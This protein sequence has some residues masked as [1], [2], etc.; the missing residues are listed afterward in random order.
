MVYVA[1]GR[2]V[3]VSDAEAAQLQT[4]GDD[5]FM[6]GYP[7]GPECWRKHAAAFAKLLKTYDRSELLALCERA[8]VPHEKW[9]NRDSAA[10]QR[11]VGEL[12]AL[13]RAG[14]SFT[15]VVENRD[16]LSVTVEFRGFNTFEEGEGMEHASF[17]LPTDACLTA[18]AGED[19]Y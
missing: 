17:Y 14:C 19:W 8:I 2:R 6:G 18:Y 13:L 15:V 3:F 7:I 12:L 16:T 4:A 11:Q 10:A 1:D 9:R 5:G